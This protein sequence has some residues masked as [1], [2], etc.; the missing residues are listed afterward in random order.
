MTVKDFLLFVLLSTA[1]FT[2]VL[3]LMTPRL[4]PDASPVLWILIPTVLVSAFGFV[5]AIYCCRFVARST[6]EELLV[7]LAGCA[8]FVTAIAGFSVALSAGVGLPAPGLTE[9]H[10]LQVVLGSTPVVFGALFAPVLRRM[11]WS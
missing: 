10:G 7:G 6:Q 5:G 3:V 9:S 2:L 1:A 11:D 8:G 4:N